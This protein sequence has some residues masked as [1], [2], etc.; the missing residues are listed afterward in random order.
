FTYDGDQ[1]GQPGTSVAA[2]DVPSGSAGLERTVGGHLH[3]A[4]WAPA[5]LPL[6]NASDYFP[7]LK[8]GVPTGG[9]TTGGKGKKTE[10]QARLWGGTAGDALD[11]NYRT[12]R[13]TVDTVNRDALGVTAPAVAFAV[14]T[15]A[16]SIEG[17]NGVP[18]REQRPP[19]RGRAV[20]IFWPAGL[21][22]GA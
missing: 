2:G 13:D 10:V 8:A 21:S 4:G 1:S 15:Y 19:E 17:V 16:Q 14:G 7:F 11:P 20:D 6:G 12:A 9:I 22:V 5:A 18:L 3:L